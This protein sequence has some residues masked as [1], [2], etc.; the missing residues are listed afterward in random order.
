MEEVLG[1]YVRIQGI[2]LVYRIFVISLQL[3]NYYN[4][5]DGEKDKCGSE[6]QH[7]H[8]AEGRKLE[9]HSQGEAPSSA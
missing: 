6:Q 2:T 5:P 3:I 8:I 7:Q 1:Q 4:V 9:H